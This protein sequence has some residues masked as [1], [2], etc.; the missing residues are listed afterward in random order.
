MA[1]PRKS[2]FLVPNVRRVRLE[3]QEARVKRSA[4]GAL[5]GAEAGLVANL[6]AAQRQR[7]VLGLKA[8]RA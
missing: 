1:F 6:G 5:S 2:F 3:P 7:V 4:C 8:H